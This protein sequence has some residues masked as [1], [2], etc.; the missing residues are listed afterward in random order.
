MSK[1]KLDEIFDIERVEKVEEK[2]MTVVSS[3]K[4]Q[5]MENDYNYARNNYYDFSEKGNQAIEGALEIALDGGHPRA[6][7]VLA[8]L[9][10]NV[11]ETNEKLIELHKSMN[12]MNPTTPTKVTNNSLFVGSTKELYKMLKE[13]DN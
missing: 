9:I 8:T 5:D 6:Y 13:K 1:K 10:K 11:G 3:G 7:E 2:G 12:E 4:Q